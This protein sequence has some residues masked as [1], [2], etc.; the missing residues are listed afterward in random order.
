MLFHS[1]VLPGKILYV[2]RMK[3]VLDVNSAFWVH[4][5][6]IDT[7]SL[8]EEEEEEEEEDEEEEEQQQQ[9]E[10]EPVLTPWQQMTMKVRLVCLLKI[11]KK[12]F[13][14]ILQ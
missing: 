8:T 13:F 7:D 9:Q 14:F 12:S 1:L 4:V 6:G 3:I 5:K 10:K 2:S 11:T